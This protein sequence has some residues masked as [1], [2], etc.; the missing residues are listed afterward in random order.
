[1][2]A[3]T[4]D[5]DRIAAIRKFRSRQ[6]LQLVNVDLFGEGFDLPAVEVVSMARP[7]A[8]R[9]LFIQQFGRGLRIM[10]DH[11]GWDSLT[12]AERR[13]HI[14]ASGKPCAII[15]DHVGN[16]HRHGLPDAPCKYTLERRERS[17]SVATD[18]EPLRTCPQC[19]GMYSR[20]LPPVCPYCGYRAEPASR[21][22]PEFV[23]GNLLEL[24]TETLAKMRGEVDKI[25]MP[26]ADYKNYLESRH[27]PYLGVLAG[28]KRHAANQAAQKQL[29]DAIAMWGGHSRAAGKRDEESYIRFYLKYGVDVLSAQALHEKDAL[30]LFN[31]IMVDIPK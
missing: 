12:D 6:I 7:T 15:I 16:V 10:V 24:D 11:D 21:R 14:A 23:V 13:A 1:M 26:A 17:A 8:S 20:Y 2:C 22:G 30:E 31:K 25:D 18:V 4:S 5:R 19:A 27:V 29:R 3:E 28:I 9:N